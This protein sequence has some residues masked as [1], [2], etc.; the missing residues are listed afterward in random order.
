MEALRVCA[1]PAVPVRGHGGR[2]WS[3][4]CATKAAQKSPRRGGITTGAP[5]PVSA[6][7]PSRR[8]D[9]RR[10]GGPT[11]KEALDAGAGADDG[12]DGANAD[13]EDDN[14]DDDYDYDDDDDDDDH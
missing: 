4:L 11:A 12:D 8:I 13:D 1:A 5:D 2:R 14:D 9:P 3:S 10:A 6:R 7:G